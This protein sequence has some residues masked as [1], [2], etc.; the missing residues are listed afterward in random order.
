SG[1]QPFSYHWQYN[2]VSNL[3]TAAN[4]PNATNSTFTITNVTTNSTGWYDVQIN[5]A[6]GAT[7]SVPVLLTVTAPLN[8]V[9]VT[10]LWSLP[11]DNS[12]PYLDTGY[13]T[14]GLAFDPST[15]T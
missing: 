3:A 15:M 10:Q 11:A 4:I 6:G 12:Q 9:S 7:S 5:N 1:S 13:N 14:R 2:T 8:N